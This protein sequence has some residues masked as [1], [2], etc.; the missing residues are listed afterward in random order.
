[1]HKEAFIVS[2]EVGSFGSIASFDSWCAGQEAYCKYHSFLSRPTWSFR[3]LGRM[4]HIK[5]SLK[6]GKSN[7]LCICH[8]R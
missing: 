5:G 7:I 6:T 8:Q 3:K 4:R 1:L 2:L